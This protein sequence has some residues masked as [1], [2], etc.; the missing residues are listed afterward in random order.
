MSEENSK[1]FDIPW[2]NIR[3]TYHYGES[4][5]ICNASWQF[6]TFWERVDSKKYIREMARKFLKEHPNIKYYVPKHGVSLFETRLKIPK[7]G[8][9]VVRILFLDYMCQTAPK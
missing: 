8:F 7:F 6:K 3:R 5:Y 2:S 4:S 9:N 1:T